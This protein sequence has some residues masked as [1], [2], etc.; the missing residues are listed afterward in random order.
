LPIKK[1]S[2]KQDDDAKG[3]SVPG[4]RKGS[5]SVENFDEL[6]QEKTKETAINISSE[7]ESEISTPDDTLDVKPALTM[8]IL[9][10]NISIA[11]NDID[12]DIGRRFYGDFCN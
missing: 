4:K 2:T 6:L 10:E 5:P 12:Q 8:K 7:E 3:K 1:T 11:L 9:N